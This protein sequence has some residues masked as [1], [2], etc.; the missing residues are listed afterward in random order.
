MMLQHT[1]TNGNTRFDARQDDITACHECGP[2]PSVMGASITDGVLEK[3]SCL[4]NTS[5]VLHSE[6]NTAHLDMTTTNTC[7]C[8]VLAVATTA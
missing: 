5:S 6:C 4:S 3:T 2:I 7:F 1:N 8:G